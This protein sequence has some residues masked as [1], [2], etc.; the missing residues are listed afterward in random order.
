VLAAK[1]YHRALPADSKLFGEIVSQ[2]CHQCGA[3]NLYC[4]SL[5]ARAAIDRSLIAGVQGFALDGGKFEL[6]GLNGTIGQLEPMKDDSHSAPGAS[7][8][9]QELFPGD[10]RPAFS[11]TAQAGRRPL[12]RVVLCHERGTA[13]RL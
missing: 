1:P 10:P 11:L 4:Q 2:F 5:L 6:G 8:G 9:A 3:T 12:G 7:C 13:G